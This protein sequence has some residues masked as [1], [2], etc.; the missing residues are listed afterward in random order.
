MT[1]ETL[2]KLGLDMRLASK[3]LQ[4]HLKDSL[5]LTVTVSDW[6]DLCDDC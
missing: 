2:G 1:I 3:N 4:L 6:H 5:N